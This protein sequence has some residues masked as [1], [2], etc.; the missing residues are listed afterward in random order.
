M[1]SKFII[2][3][4]FA[5]VAQN[6]FVLSANKSTSVILSDISKIQNDQDEERRSTREGVTDMFNG[7]LRSAAQHCFCDGDNR[8][9]YTVSNETIKKL[10]HGYDVTFDAMNRTVEQSDYVVHGYRDV[11]YAYLDLALAGFNVALDLANSGRYSKFRSNVEDLEV[12][13]TLG[14]TYPTQSTYAFLRTSLKLD[15]EVEAILDALESKSIAVLNQTAA[16]FMN[17]LKLYDNAVSGEACKKGVAVLDDIEN[18]KSQALSLLEE[19]GNYQFTAISAI[20]THLNLKSGGPVSG[21]HDRRYALASIMT[22]A[23]EALD[24]VFD[25][26]SRKMNDYNLRLRDAGKT[27]YSSID[28]LQ[29]VYNVKLRSIHDIFSNI[30]RESTTDNNRSKVQ[31]DMDAVTDSIS[32]Y[33]V[34]IFREIRLSDTQN[35]NYSVIR[36]E[37]DVSE[38]ELPHEKLV[39]SMFDWIRDGNQN[40][41]S[42]LLSKI[43]NLEKIAL[44]HVKSAYSRVFDAMKNVAKAYHNMETEPESNFRSKSIDSAKT[45]A[46]SVFAAIEISVM[47]TRG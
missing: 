43:N 17:A 40:I 42:E 23:E 25:V 41:G 29:S 16:T 38:K 11:A 24:A 10:Q 14:F 8:T 18:Q 5:S 47:Q 35:R 1:S 37:M 9:N 7:I 44:G 3:L 32:Q 33:S 31:K 46:R 34:I 13:M 15:E 26:L 20:Y 6:S 2:F 39:K 30:I 45:F 19:R 28:T 21:I 36:D 12:A 4:V 22:K 27:D